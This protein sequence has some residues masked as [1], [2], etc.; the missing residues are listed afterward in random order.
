MPRNR[1][2]TTI[3]ISDPTLVQRA[4]SL[5]HGLLQLPQRA[6]SI[7][8]PI[9][10]AG[11]I[12]QVGP[13]H[14]DI[15]GRPNSPFVKR[16]GYKQINEYPMLWNHDKVGQNSQNILFVRPDGHGEVRRN[17]E[18]ADEQ[19]WNDSATHLHIN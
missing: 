19:M 10:T 16:D 3:R 18:V 14:R 2:W 6:A 1:K 12:A 9:V 7:E 11:S 15:N 13:V 4:K 17:R 5:A 8:I